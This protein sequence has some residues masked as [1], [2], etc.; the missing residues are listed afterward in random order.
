MSRTWL[1]LDDRSRVMEGVAIPWGQTHLT[2][3]AGGGGGSFMMLIEWLN[4][5]WVSK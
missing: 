1:L 2:A 4:S 5:D 3:S